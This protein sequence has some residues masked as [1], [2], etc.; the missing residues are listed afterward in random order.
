MTSEH[1]LDP[2]TLSAEDIVEF[3]RSHIQQIVGEITRGMAETP[4][5]IERLCAALV[6]YW[7]A[8]YARR[9]VRRMIV[10]AAAGT[11]L[12]NELDR[13]GKPFRHLLQLELHS[14][15]HR[16]KP[17]IDTIFNEAKAIT[18]E[19]ATS[20]VRAMARRSRLIIAI[21]SNTLTDLAPA[22]T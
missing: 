6:T 17:T 15:G 9:S 22:A 20:G 2:H 5:G 4:A 13:I 16:S 3:F 12:E 19:E 7:E 11:S 14:I 21:R 8:G 10:N 18:L 1:I